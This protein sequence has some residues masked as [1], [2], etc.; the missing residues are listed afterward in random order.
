MAEPITITIGKG[1][2]ADGTSP[3]GQQ[4]QAVAEKEPGK[5]NFQQ[6]AVNAA[7]INAAKQVA[8]Q[9]VRAYGNITG[10]YAMVDSINTVMSIGADV[11]TVAKGGWVGAIAV[12]SKYAISIGN[13]FIESKRNQFE[14]SLGMERAGGVMEGNNFYINGSRGTNG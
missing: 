14:Y 11:L 4:Q 1:Q 9:G 8:M 12:G 6:Q 7:L 13:S 3:G 2:Q 5:P 10:D